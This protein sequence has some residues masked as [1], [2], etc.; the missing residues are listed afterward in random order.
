MQTYLVM[1]PLWGIITPTSIMFQAVGYPL[2]STI[3]SFSRQLLFNI[4]TTLLLPLEFGL[5]GYLYAGP[6]TDILSF[7]LA[8]VL[9]KLYWKKMFDPKTAKV[10]GT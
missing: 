3:Q 6:L 8:V 4:P 10:L 2:Q 1:I 7:T 9:M 5:D